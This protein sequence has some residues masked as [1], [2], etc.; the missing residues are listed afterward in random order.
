MAVQQQSPSRATSRQWAALCVLA[1]AVLLLAVDG[2][3]LSLAIPALSQQL[4]PSATQ[5]LWIGDA[6]SFALAGLLVTMGT[7]GDRIGRKRLLLI[8]ATGFA[9]AS[10]LAA[11]AP[12]P[13]WL[14][15]ARVLLGVAGA[16]LMPSTL[17]IIRNMFTDARQ[18]TTAVAVWGAM[19]TAG[20]AAGP[21]VGGFLLEHFWWGSVFVINL[22][23]MAL[24]LILG[25]P[26][27]PESRDPHPGR[28]DPLSALLS[29]LGIV[30]VV[31]AVKELA[32]HGVTPTAGITAAAGIAAIIM[33]VRRQR[34]LTTPL[35][36]VT[37]FRR[38]A[39]TGAVSANLLSIFALSGLLFFVSQYLQLVQG[40][41]PLQAGVRQLP[42]TLA[43]LAVAVVIGALAARIGHGP[44]IGIGLVIAAGGLV[45][46]AAAEG[47]GSYPWLATAF[48]AIGLGVGAALTLTTDAVISA[49]PPNKAGAA[50]A[51]SETAYELGVALGIAILGSLHTA[52]Y[53]THLTVPADVP[54]PT[55]EAARESLA[56][57]TAVPSTPLL[58]LARDAF[59]SAMQAT[60]LIAALLLAAAGLLAWKLI[61]ADKGSDQNVSFGSTDDPER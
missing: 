32:S 6:Y 45:L 58:D 23:I 1:L 44:L 28:F 39:F 36:D 24:L 59:V 52:L 21:L 15:A 38:P 60:S 20:A 5:L 49:V 54:D 56:S 57:A 31:Y 34:A 16:T 61:S 17:S 55:A 4:Q 42:L 47:T 11:F 13:G 37:L 8:G 53:R 40:Y 7:L 35:I 46:L 2:T 10:L 9:G 22:P 51:V 29:V 33:F 41:S 30:P 19:A 14:I 48:V 3:V 43:S 26:L 25:I 12:S 50:S 18:R 27:I